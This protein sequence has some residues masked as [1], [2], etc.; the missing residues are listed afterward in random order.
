MEKLH[1]GTNHIAV[2]GTGP[3]TGTLF[4]VPFN[5]SGTLCWILGNKL[6]HLKGWRTLADGYR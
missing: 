4:E 1:T 2:G 5:H 6:P 3:S